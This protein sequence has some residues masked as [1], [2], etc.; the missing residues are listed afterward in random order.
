MLD[1]SF[2]KLP[3]FGVEHNDLIKETIGKALER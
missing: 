1:Q 2:P 3:F